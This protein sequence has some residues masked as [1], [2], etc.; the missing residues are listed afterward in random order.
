MDGSEWIFDGTLAV[1]GDDF[2]SSIVGPPVPAMVERVKK[3]IEEGYEVRIFTARVSTDGTDARNQ[4][5]TL[6]RAAIEAWSEAN[7]GTVLPITN[8]KDYAM[9]EL[10]DDR[11]VQVIPNTGRT[12]ADELASERSALVGK[13]AVLEKDDNYYHGD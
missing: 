7:L 11:C 8:V 4:D 3:W 1:Y 6:A 10:W 12:I 13:A 5:V 9:I 2:S